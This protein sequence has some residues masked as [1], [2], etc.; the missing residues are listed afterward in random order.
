M[1][2]NNDKI[3]EA[4]R[5]HYRLSREHY[6]PQSPSGVTNGCDCLVCQAVREQ[7]DFRDWFVGDK[8]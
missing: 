4:A 7:E 1:S 2:N 8:E 5:E 6:N 3:V